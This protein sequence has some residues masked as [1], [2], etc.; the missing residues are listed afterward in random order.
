M[1]INEQHNIQDIV[2]RVGVAALVFIVAA[3]VAAVLVSVVYLFSLLL[4]MKTRPNNVKNKYL[5]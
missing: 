1:Q 4:R 3:N 5:F 2:V